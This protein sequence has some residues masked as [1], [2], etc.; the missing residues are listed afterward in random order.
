MLWAPIWVQAATRSSD[1]RND[2][3]GGRLFKCWCVRLGRREQ[4]QTAT[5]EGCGLEGGPESS[6]LRAWHWGAMQG[7]HWLEI[8]FLSIDLS[9]KHLLRSCLVSKSCPILLWPYSPPGSSVHGISQARIE[10][11]VAI[12][13]SKGSSRPRDGACTSCFGSQFLYHWTTWE[14]HL[15]KRWKDKSVSSVSHVKVN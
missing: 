8:H 10:E 1:S 6:G 5:L 15:L 3:A 12:S 11:G 14:A 13:F 4:T 2:L 9:E 7:F